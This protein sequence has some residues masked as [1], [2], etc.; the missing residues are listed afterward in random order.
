MFNQR[1]LERVCAGLGVV[2]ALW[3]PVS[4]SFR[5]RRLALNDLD[6]QRRLPL[7]RPPF[8]AVVHRHTSRYFPLYSMS[9][10]S[11]GHYMGRA[12]A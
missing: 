2:R 6:D 10:F 3:W 5:H 12:N 8:D 7:R 11:M 9:R 4:S 1:L